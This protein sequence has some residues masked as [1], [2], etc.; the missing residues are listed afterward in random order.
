MRTTQPLPQRPEHWS[1][2]S[3]WPRPHDTVDVPG[4]HLSVVG[5]HARTTAEA[6]RDGTEALGRPQAG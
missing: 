5:V 2:W 1:S 6:I 4:T 3:S